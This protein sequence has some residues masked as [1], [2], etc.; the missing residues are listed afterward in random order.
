MNYFSF[1]TESVW[2]IRRSFIQVEV[3]LDHHII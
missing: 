2:E 3:Y 1:S